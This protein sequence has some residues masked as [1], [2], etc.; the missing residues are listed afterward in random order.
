MFILLPLLPRRCGDDGE[1]LACS[2][3]GADQLEPNASGVDVS[4]GQGLVIV[5]CLECR[6]KTTT[7]GLASRELR[8][9]AF[10]LLLQLRKLRSGR[11][12]AGRQRL[13]LPEGTAA[14]R[15]TH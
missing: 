12:S 7:F 6:P 5:L 4:D 1:R 10:D 14:R 3:L 15:Q 9:Q 13:C 11:R 8:P 2:G